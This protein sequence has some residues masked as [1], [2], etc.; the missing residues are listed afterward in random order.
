MAG[1]ERRLGLEHENSSL[2][3]E[4]ERWGGSGRGQPSPGRRFLRCRQLTHWQWLF[5]G[6]ASAGDLSGAQRSGLVAGHRFP[7]M[8][9]PAGGAPP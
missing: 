9:T 4:D 6:Q 1:D 3:E 5:G 2:S 7:D 8:E